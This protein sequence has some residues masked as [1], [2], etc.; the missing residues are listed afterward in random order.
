MEDKEKL[1][2]SIFYAAI[3]SNPFF[4]TFIEKCFNEYKKEAWK[5]YKKSTIKNSTFIQNM[6][7]KSFIQICK[8]IAI[9]EYMQDCYTNDPDKAEVI[10]AK[11]IKALVGYA[12]E[13]FFKAIQ[14][15]NIRKLFK[16]L[17]ESRKNTILHFN[18]ILILW[19]HEK[20]LFLK[21]GLSEKL[22]EEAQKKY[23]SKIEPEHIENWIKENYEDIINQRN[24]LGFNFKDKSPSYIQD[25]ISSEENLKITTMALG[26]LQFYG[27]DFNVLENEFPMNKRDWEMICLY[28]AKNSQISMEWNYIFGVMQVFGKAYSS[29]RELF[30]KTNSEF[31]ELEEKVFKDNQ[32]EMLSLEK[33]YVKEIEKKDFEIERLQ[34]EYRSSLEREIIEK[35]KE[36]ERMQELLENAYKKEIEEEIIQRKNEEQ[37]FEIF[38][39]DK[40]ITLV[41]GFPKLNQRIK[42]YF[43]NARF[44]NNPV[45][46]K[47][48]IFLLTRYM[49]HTEQNVFN[50]SHLQFQRID[51]LGVN[52]IAHEIKRHV[53]E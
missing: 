36:L 38:I 19:M 44:E 45:R 5:F 43:P 24:K 12:G 41:G 3:F 50:A 13:N 28:N 11:I 39:D 4:N 8:F 10:N 52:Q 35:D 18:Q 48:K 51:G 6:S 17:E 37:I 47:G 25:K 23:V 42:K 2:I 20:D 7:I 27:V 40:E 9:W 33:N 30:F 29:A 34:K 21:L 15:K 31:I 16:I 46:A 49:S 32:R 14:E 26:I 22:I 53:N 1:S